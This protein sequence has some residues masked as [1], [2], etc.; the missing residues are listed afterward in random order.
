MSDWAGCGDF[1]LEIPGARLHARLVPWDEAV[2]GYPVAQIDGIEAESQRIGAEAVQRF[3]SWADRVGIGMASCR[4][5]V[6]RLSEGMALEAHGFRFVEVVLHPWTASLADAAI[7]EAG[8]TILAAA[9]EDLPELEVMAE[10]AFQHGRIHADPRLGPEL[11]SRRYR[12]WVRSCLGHPR[13][14]LLKVSLSDRTIALFVVE[15]L[16]NGTAYWHLTAM[17][18]AF[19]GQGYG[20]RVWRAMLAWHALRGATAVST[21]ITAGNIAVMN[22]YVKLGFRFQAPEM[23]YHW[24]RGA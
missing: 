15:H 4:L 17:A 20:E 13:Q 23:T 14:R 21:T 9:P 19:Q 18:P 24:V 11:G 22:L 2:F 8:L 16:H 7:D 1:H 12:Q 5:P 3:L 6:S 10:A